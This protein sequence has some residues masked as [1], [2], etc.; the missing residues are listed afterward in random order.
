MS[1]TH[2]RRGFT[3]IELLVV[4]AIIA[5]LIGLLLPAVQKVREAAA[6]SDSTNKLKQIGIAFQSAN[7]TLGRLP[8][9]GTG[10]TNPAGATGYTN[11]GFHSP[12]VSGSGTWASQI[13][14]FMEQNTLFT[15]VV[16]TSGN[17]TTYW[18]SAPGSGLVSVPV[19]PY[20]CAGRGRAGYKNSTVSGSQNGNGPVSD[21]AINTFIND[22]PNV[23]SPNGTSPQFAASTQAASTMNLLTSPST[24][25]SY[26]K[27][28]SKMTIQGIQDGSSQTILVGGKAGKPAELNDPTNFSGVGSVGWDSGIFVGGFAGTGRSHAPTAVGGTNPVKLVRDG[29]N[30][31]VAYNWGGP[32]SGGVLFMYGDGTVRSVNYNLSGNVNFALQLYPSDGG[33][34]NFDN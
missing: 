28:D 9:N 31:D 2:S 5:I 27:A 22:S 33:V 14:P 10:G 21:F 17:P 19:K 29:P 4:I 34:I 23:Y 8:Y 24:G 7:D 6:R 15:S 32:F 18:N 26:S 20:L 11:G 16:M 1:H 25:G 13:L 3:L 30:A 12:N